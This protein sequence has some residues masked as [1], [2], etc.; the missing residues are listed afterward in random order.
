MHFEDGWVYFE[1]V[2]KYQVDCLFSFI[3]IVLEDYLI[4]SSCYQSKQ[5]G[6]SNK[7]A[8]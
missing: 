7:L 6:E 5:V 4:H 1:I 8:C 3:T 2:G